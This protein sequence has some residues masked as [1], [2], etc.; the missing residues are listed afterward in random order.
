LEKPDVSTRRSIFSS[1]IADLNIDFTDTGYFDPKD[2]NDLMERISMMSHSK[3]AADI[4]AIVENA[5]MSA[6]RDIIT[7]KSVD[8]CDMCEQISTMS[9]SYKYFL[10]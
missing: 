9:I 6:L 7:C 2:K 1:A 3:S 4:I 10:T 5:K 8:E